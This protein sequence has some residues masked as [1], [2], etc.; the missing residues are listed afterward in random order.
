VC[1]CVLM[2]KQN[3]KEEKCVRDRKYLSLMEVK[4][5]VD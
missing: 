5:S 2:Y 3:D 1:A 4:G